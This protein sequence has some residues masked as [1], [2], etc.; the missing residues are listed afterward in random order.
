MMLTSSVFACF[1]LK[2]SL[3]CHCLFSELRRLVIEKL[4]VS[5]W[6]CLQQALRATG[7]GDALV[8]GLLLCLS[9]PEGSSGL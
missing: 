6:A 2:D 5:S 3:R 8:W 4:S 9:G 1:H 7:H